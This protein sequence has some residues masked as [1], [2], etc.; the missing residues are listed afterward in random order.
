MEKVQ[1]SEITEK[2]VEN[3]MDNSNVWEKAMIAISEQ[4]SLVLDDFLSA[5]KGLGNYSISDSSARNNCLPVANSYEFLGSLDYA[6]GYSAG[7]LSDEQIEKANK[8]VSDYLDSETDDQREQLESDMDKL[9][10]EYAAT[11]LSAVVDEYD[12]IYDRDYVKDFMMD[13][14]EYMYSDSAFYNREDNSIYYMVKD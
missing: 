11:I 3:L 1:L 12:V 7:V 6:C 9:A 2:D 8:L 14:L 5:L 4:T 13:A 10:G